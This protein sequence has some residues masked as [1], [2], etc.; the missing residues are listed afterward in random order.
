MINIL[1]IDQLL[2][3]IFYGNYILMINFEGL[4]KSQNILK[5]HHINLVISKKIL[6]SCKIIYNLYQLELYS[7][8]ILWLH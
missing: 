1:I 2:F 5:L 8:N 6:Y 4:V 3:F 7:Q